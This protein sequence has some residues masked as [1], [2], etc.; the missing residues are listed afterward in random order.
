ML[1][2]MPR[3]TANNTIVTFNDKF[4]IFI[5]PGNQ[6]EYSIFTMNPAGIVNFPEDVKY[7]QDLQIL[8]KKYG[9]RFIYDIFLDVYNLTNYNDYYEKSYDTT[10]GKIINRINE[11][12]F[13]KTIVGDE[14][15]TLTRTMILLYSIMVSEELRENAPLG[16]NLKRLSMYQVMLEGMNPVD[17]ANFSRG[18]KFPTLMQECTKRFGS[19]SLKKE[20]RF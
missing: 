17:A 1:I 13:L 11:H 14:L 3:P 7:F 2:Q 18:K 19:V 12:T 4:T 10:I 9:N 16:K 20:K 15:Q 8:G 5:A 6:D